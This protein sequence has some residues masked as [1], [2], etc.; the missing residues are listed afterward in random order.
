MRSV[1]AAMKHTPWSSAQGA[2]LRDIGRLIHARD[3]PAAEAAS[4]RLTGAFPSFAAGWHAASQTAFGQGRAAEALERIDTALALEPRSVQFLIHRARCLLAL[5]RLPQACE[6]AAAALRVAPPDPRVF[7]AIG[8]IFSFG[9]DPA[10][11][12]AAY[13][14]AV[15][16]APDDPLFVFNRAAVRRFLGDLAGAEADYDRVIALK[17]ADYE[18]YKNR[19]DLRPQTLER[20]HIGQLER[21]AAA[22]VA[23]WRGAVQIH[24]ALA[25]EHEDLGDHGRAFEWLQRGSKIRRAHIRYDVKNDVATAAWIAEAFPTAPGGPTVGASDAAPIFIVGLPRTGTTLVDRIVGSHSQIQ[26]AGEL[27]HFAFAVV[28]AARGRSGRAHLPR[29]E[30]IAQSAGVDFAALGRDYL[31]RVNAASTIPRRFTDKMPLNYLYCGLIRR[32]LP[33]ARIVHL[34]RHPMAACYAMYKTLFA[35]GYP[36]SYDLDEIASYYIAYRRLMDHWQSTMPDGIL[37]LH[38]E[39]LVADQ[40]G[41]TRRLLAFCDLPWEDACVRFH[42]NPAPSTTASAAQVRRPLYDSSVA[43]WRHYASELA[44]LGSRLAAAGIDIS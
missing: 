7:D 38:Y 35:D 34:N 31:A 9:N 40:V 30:L 18:A 29:R 44:G 5:G 19:S 33:N 21:L 4:L 17:P 28:D 11:A 3:W 8:G 14:A 42:E 26:S 10:R 37:P 2:A 32:A 16:L 23:D 41:E 24:Y 12:L 39:A 6:G 13:D 43:Q 15:K 36:F 20:N 27:T 25:K 1:P 22:G